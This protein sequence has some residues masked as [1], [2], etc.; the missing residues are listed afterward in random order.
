MVTAVDYR[1]CNGVWFFGLAGAGKS[2]ASQIGAEYLKNAF[3]IDGDDVRALVSF[4]LGYSLSD[5]E[6]QIKRV[7]GIAHIAIKNMQT[8]II[9]TVTMSDEIYESCNQL[10]IK[11]AQIIRPVDQILKVRN[12]YETERNVVGQDIEQKDFNVPK[13][14]NNGDKKFEGLIKTFV[15]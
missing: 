1:E 15:G 10:G 14:Y 13:L 9:S 8:P 7:F 12:I 6:I 11:I 4:D 5:R 3:I 2:F